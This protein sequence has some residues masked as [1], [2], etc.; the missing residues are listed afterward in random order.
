MDAD[1]LVPAVK[2]KINSV[3]DLISGRQLDV[4][5]ANIQE[6]RQQIGNSETLQRAAS[7][8]DRIR[9]SAGKVHSESS[10]VAPIASPAR[11][12]LRQ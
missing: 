11:T 9:S 5:E 6:L 3:F 7:T 4:A 1:E 8:I 12:K 2:K 10:R